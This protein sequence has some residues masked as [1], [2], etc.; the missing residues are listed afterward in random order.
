MFEVQEINPNYK[1]NNIKVDI[2][3]KAKKRIESEAVAT[4]ITVLNPQ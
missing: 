2:L 3:L 1:G 4:P